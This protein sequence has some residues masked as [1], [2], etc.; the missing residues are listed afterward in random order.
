MPA[1]GRGK[2]FRTELG[3]DEILFGPKRAM[4]PER[5]AL[6]FF[7]ASCPGKTSGTSAPVGNVEGQ[8]IYLMEKVHIFHKNGVRHTDAGGGII[9]NALDARL[10]KLRGCALRAF[11][12]GRDDPDFN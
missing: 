8:G 6:R 7:R 11:R 4:K 1:P 3:A 2:G 5:T 12:R 10:D 9:E